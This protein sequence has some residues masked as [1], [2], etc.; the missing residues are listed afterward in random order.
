MKIG[1]KKSKKQ[2]PLEIAQKETEFA[3]SKT[4]EKINELG[5]YAKNL[6]L[7]LNDIQITFDEIR[8]IPSDDK[9]EYEQIKE[10]RINWKQQVDNIQTDYK[11]AIEKNTGTGI[12][13][14]GAGA[15][16][17]ALGPSAAMGVATTFGVASTGTAISTL[18]GAAATNAALAWLGGGAL[19]AGGQGMAAGGVLL[20][21]FG[22]LGIAIAG[23]TSIATGIVFFSQKSN[24]KR[25]DTIFIKMNQRETNNYKLAEVEL[26][27]R[28]IHI[29]KECKILSDAIE[30]VKSFGTDYHAMAEEQ[31]SELGS[32]LNQMNASTLLLINP[33]SGLQPSFSEMDFENY[34]SNLHKSYLKYY[35][36]TDKTLIMYFANLF[37]DIELDSKDI[38]QL[39][40]SYRKNKVFLKSMRMSKKQFTKNVFNKAFLALENKS[41][42][43]VPRPSSSK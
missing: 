31:Q 23:L 13:G 3:L 6:Y 27:E 8:N 2:N 14:V 1:H 35:A 25:L 38:K 33:I 21:L 11:K 17:M 32:Y 4:N 19:V 40:K 37:Y 41:S 30:K 34:V 10:V 7:K 43:Q 20:S 24:Q 22:P 28:I 15:T 16:V 18:S 5:K 29:D 12:L 39:W 26:K 36:K 42:L 9:L